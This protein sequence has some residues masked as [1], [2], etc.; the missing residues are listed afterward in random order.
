MPLASRLA[1]RFRPSPH[2]RDRGGATVD[3]IVVH[4]ISCPPGNLRDTRDIEDLFLGRLDPARHPAYREV[5][6]KALSAHFL[7]DRRGRVTQFVETGRAAFHAGASRWGGREG[8]NDF[9]VGIELV[10]TGERP[11][12]ARQYAAL[13]RLCRDLMRAHPAIAPGRIVGHSDVALP[14]GRKGDPG[15]SFDW[16]RLRR[17]LARLAVAGVRSRRA[18]RRPRRVTHAGRIER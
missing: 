6:G 16:A 8:C 2:H 10:G 11:F 14:P 4:H 1:I 7:V 12:T 18:V 17:E 9:S 15:P 5:A 13:A 3:L